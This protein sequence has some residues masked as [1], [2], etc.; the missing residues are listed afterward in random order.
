M[1]ISNQTRFG[2][3]DG[4]H[5]AVGKRTQPTI[6]F[7]LLVRFRDSRSEPRYDECGLPGVA[8]NLTDGYRE[9][10]SA[11]EFKRIM[12]PRVIFGRA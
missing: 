9:E 10:S 8:V 12:T 1:D 7:N 5:I 11:H 3:V 4:T 2:G 6:I